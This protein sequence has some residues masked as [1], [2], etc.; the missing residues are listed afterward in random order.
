[1]EISAAALKVGSKPLP[2]NSTPNTPRPCRAIRFDPK[3]MVDPITLLPVAAAPALSLPGA[4]HAA[5][6]TGHVS[7]LAP[8]LF[9][10]SQP[11][12]PNFQ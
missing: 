8:P 1:M 5:S 4:F 9:C 3:T 2:R 11:I 12:D 6:S 10:F 7:H